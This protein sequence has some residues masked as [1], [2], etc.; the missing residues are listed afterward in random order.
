M[1]RSRVLRYRGKEQDSCRQNAFRILEESILLPI[2][3]KKVTPACNVFEDQI[4]WA[5]SPVRIDLAGGWTD[6]PPYSV[7]SGGRVVNMSLELNGQPPLQAYIRPT[8]ERVI[9]L[10][11][12]DLGE[13]EIIRT[14][15][16]LA[17]YNLVGSPFV[18]PKAALCLSGFHPDFCG[19]PYRDLKSQLNAFGSGLEISFLAAIPKGSGMGTSSNLAATILGGLSD[20]CSLGWDS[21]EICNRTLGLEQLL[22]TGGGWQ[23]QY[24]GVFPGV[25]L[26]E[27]ESGWNQIPRLR[28][29]PEKIFTDPNSQSSMLLFYT[30]I[31][32]VAKN[33]LAEIVEGMF[34]NEK[35]KLTVL[36]E[37]KQ[38]A[39]DTWETIQLGDYTQY[40]KQIAKTWEQKKRLDADT[41]NPEIENIIRKID[42]LSLGYKL[43]GAG[44]GGFLYICAK[45][46]HAALSI[47]KSLNE[48][49]INPR[50]RFVEM[51]I[52]STGLKVSRS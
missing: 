11:S 25:K 38:H 22:T 14:Y 50:A 17:G 32:R 28:W 45:D 34:L 20:F 8:T 31:T 16:E 15:E 48:E 3:E 33:L 37:M 19:E 36:K 7:L 47:K 12:I 41:T 52:S 24:G 39:L 43:P 30:G 9:T 5:R 46:P 40:G 49:P 44:G 2:R 4:V 29:L 26:L 23:D 35:E 21:F 27:T 42:D 13:R 10:R 1:F 18:I 6:T 51:N